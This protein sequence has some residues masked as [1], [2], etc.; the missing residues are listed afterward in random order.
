MQKKYNKLYK[1]DFF[2]I[3]NYEK[4]NYSDKSIKECR[5]YYLELENLD[6]ILN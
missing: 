5:K 4:E 1:S 3:F 6:L 2:N